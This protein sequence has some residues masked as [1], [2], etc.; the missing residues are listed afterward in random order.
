VN[1]YRVIPGPVAPIPCD[2]AEQRQLLAGE[3]IPPVTPWI[4]AIMV[5]NSAGHT[6]GPSGTSAG[7][8]RG[9]DRL[10]LG[11]YREC[12]DVVLVGASTIRAERVPTPRTSA[13]AIISPSGDLQAHQLVVRDGALVG[14]V[15]TPEG[16]VRLAETFAAVPH[17]ALII[18][19]P[20]PFSSAEIL[21]A[22]AS[23]YSL[24]HVLVEGGVALWQTFAPITDEL[25]LAVTPPPL[26]HH[27]GVPEWWPG[28]S[29]QWTLHS[30]WSDDEKMLY[31]RYL[32]GVRGAP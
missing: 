6:V 32:T 30:L 15:T 24:E 17:T 23:W 4:R 22:L 2:T 8:T 11:L 12:A 25:A 16:A 19:A 29:S 5:A 26:D 13:L 21:G 10:L 18:D 14:V 20:A 27:G 31:Y 7:L 1:L 9:A 28:E 3:L